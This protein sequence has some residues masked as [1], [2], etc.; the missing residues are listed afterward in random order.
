MNAQQKRCGVLAPTSAVA[1]KFQ[2]DQ[3]QGHCSRLTGPWD[4]MLG[5]SAESKADR[6]AVRIL[7][8]QEEQCMPSVDA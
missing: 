3:G 2:T 7:L 5:N 1:N 8:L 6:K 4:P